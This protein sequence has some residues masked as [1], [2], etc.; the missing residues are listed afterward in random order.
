MVIGGDDPKSRPR[1]LPKAHDGPTL[2]L[3]TADIE[4]K[5]RCFIAGD[6]A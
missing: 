3:T 4:V 2:S 6:L 1:A 5:R